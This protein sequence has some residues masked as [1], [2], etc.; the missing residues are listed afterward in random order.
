MD[1]TGHAGRRPVRQWV[2]A[3]AATLSLASITIRSTTTRAAAVEQQP[4]AF[5]PKVSMVRDLD[6]TFIPL[7]D[8]TVIASAVVTRPPYS[9]D[10]SGRSDATAAIQRAL[11]DVA[12]A[13][14]GVKTGGDLCV[15]SV[16]GRADLLECAGLTAL[17][18]GAA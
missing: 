8:E 6:P 12:Q 7:D 14:N 10:P 18:P 17:S 13:W 15:C 3:A 9:A 5:A 1:T 16:V 4:R 2:A 11:D